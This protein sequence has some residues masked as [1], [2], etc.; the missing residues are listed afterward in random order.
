MFFAMCPGPF[1]SLDEL[2]ELLMVAA[3]Y[4]SLPLLAALAFA[5]WVGA[6]RNR[7]AG[8]YSLHLN[9]RRD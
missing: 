3:A 9:D 7:L 5:K 4:F 1:F 2:F 6:R 8:Q